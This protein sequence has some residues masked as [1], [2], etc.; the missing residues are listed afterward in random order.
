MLSLG[1]GSKGGICS[2]PKIQNDSD[3]AQRLT[4]RFKAS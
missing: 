3:F 1:D 4:R 2:A